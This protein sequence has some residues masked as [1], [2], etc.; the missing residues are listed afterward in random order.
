MSILDR[1]KLKGHLDER[2]LADLWAGAT[3]AGVQPRH[4]HLETCASCRVQMAEFAGWLGD[5][6][7]DARAEA[8]EA[9]TRERLVAQQA[10]IAR[11]I[12]AAERPA[13]IIAFPR[14]TR[15]MVGTAGS[16]R[17][18]IAGAAAA[19][20]IAGVG[21]GNYMDL[22]HVRGPLPPAS[23]AINQG[24][25]GPSQVDR[26]ASGIVQAATSL[27]DEELMWR[28]EEVSSPQLPESLLAIESM[29]PRARDYPR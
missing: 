14:F 29:T 6:R 15:P 27:S 5:I 3:A 10:Q 7:V 17:R 11:R 28:L 19:G 1:L 8:D 25:T 21:L 9:F 26:P 13:R 24:S 18:W 22:R 16:A 12:E 2:A 4:P 23:Q 20:L